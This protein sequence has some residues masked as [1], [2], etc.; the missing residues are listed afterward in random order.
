MEVAAYPL[1]AKAAAA[2][3]RIAAWR[4]ARGSGPLGPVGGAG[5]AVVVVVI[6][7]RRSIT[8]SVYTMGGAEMSQPR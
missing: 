1:R 2:P 7:I 8:S 6:G 5:A 3:E 4:S